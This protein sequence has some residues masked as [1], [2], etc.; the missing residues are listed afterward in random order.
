M[1]RIRQARPWRERGVRRL[2]SRVENEKHQQN[3]S[4]CSGNG[5]GI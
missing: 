3:I 4:V 2:D 5:Y 1:A